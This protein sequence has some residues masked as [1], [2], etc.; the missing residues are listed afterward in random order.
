MYN[1]ILL[2]S[3]EVILLSEIINYYKDNAPDN[4]INA[5]IIQRHI[6]GQLPTKNHQNNNQMEINPQ[7][8]KLNTK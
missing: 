2:T 5:H 4:A 3:K 8:H 1:K 6:M 7:L